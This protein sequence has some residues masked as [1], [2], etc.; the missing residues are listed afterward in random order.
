[1]RHKTLPLLSK[2]LLICFFSTLGM[3]QNDDRIIFLVR[4]AEKASQ[5]KD[6]LLSEAGHKRAECL[7]NL[8]RDAQIKAIFVTQVVRTQQTAEPLAKQL[9]LTPTVVGSSN[10]NGLVE[11][12]HSTSAG[13]VL[14][15]AHS[16]T[17]PGIIE[18]LGGGAIRAIGSAE[19][20]QLVV[21]QSGNSKSSAAVTLRYCDCGND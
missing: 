10:L 4:H 6:A 21:L 8:L 5:E 12:L 20:D 9:G 18:K 14:V 2:L 11:K 19:Y 17:L 3:A 7:A 1:M 15:V 16:D 13:V